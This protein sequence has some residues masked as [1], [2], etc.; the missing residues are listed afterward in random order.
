ME[1]K[2]VKWDRRNQR[3][4]IIA[5][6]LAV[7]FTVW[8]WSFTHRDKA[9]EPA[10]TAEK[11]AE[12][13]RVEPEEEES[14]YL[15]SAGEEKPEPDPSAPEEPEE[16]EPVPEPVPEEEPAEP[17]ADEPDGGSEPET[18][19]REPEWPEWPEWSERVRPPRRTVTGTVGSVPL[20]DDRSRPGRD[21]A[22]Q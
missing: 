2:S 20:W 21:P 19:W 3:T 18:G 8:I 11:P 17:E 7:L 22:P 15:P 14:L 16:P 9:P 13:E 6:I 1:D 10:E 4:V 12:P 5:G